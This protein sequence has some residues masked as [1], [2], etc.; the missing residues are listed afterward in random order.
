VAAR[1]FGRTLAEAGWF[2]WTDVVRAVAARRHPSA[3][4]ARVRLRA[5]SGALVLLARR[6]SR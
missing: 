1:A 6:P 5:V 2:V 3:A 4:R